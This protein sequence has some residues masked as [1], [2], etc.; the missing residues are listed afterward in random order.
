MLHGSCHCGAV[1]WRFEA[2]PQSATACNCTICRRYGVRE[3]SLFGSAARDE[4]AS[5]S[6]VDVLIEFEPSAGVGLLGLQTVQEELEAIFQ[7]P[8]DL[9]TSAILRNPFRRRSILRDLRKI[10]VA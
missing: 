2:M 8:V 10:Y 3:L 7:R 9:A 5:D 6:D 4:L 1:N